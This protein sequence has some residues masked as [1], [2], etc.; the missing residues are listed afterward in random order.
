VPPEPRNPVPGVRSRRR[1]IVVEGAGL[2]FALLV[3]G[4]SIMPSWGSAAHAAARPEHDPKLAVATGGPSPA[5]PALPAD[6]RLA[7]SRPSPSR[8]VGWLREQGLAV[9]PTAGGAVPA[10]AC[11]VASFTDPNAPT[12][13]LIAAY[14]DP[15]SAG[16]AAA[17]PGPQ[18]GLRI[19]FAAGIYVMILDPA[20]SGLRVQ[21]Q[22]MLDAYVAQSNPALVTPSPTSTTAP[23][24]T[25]RRRSSSRK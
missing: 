3:T 4:S 2:G 5:Q 9:S 6:C 18:A 19:R 16:T 15:E 17:A 1:R 7:A 21:Y 10:G 8:V 20:L 22:A 12:P 25:T 24:S 14:P 23:V 11:A 13:N